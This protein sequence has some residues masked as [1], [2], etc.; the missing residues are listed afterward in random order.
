MQKSHRRYLP[1][2]PFKRAHI[3]QD[4]ASLSHHN[5]TFIFIS[6]MQ[7]YIVRDHINFNSG[8]SQVCLTR[9]LIKCR[10]KQC[11]HKHIGLDSGPPVCIK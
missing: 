1:L 11:I 8:P 7:R 2:T 9:A 5:G 3:L 6:K 4:P 10:V